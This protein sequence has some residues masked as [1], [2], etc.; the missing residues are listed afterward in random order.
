MENAE[1]TVNT[2]DEEFDKEGFAAD[3]FELLND[4]IPDEE[5]FE[6]D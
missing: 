5:D 1:E 2:K 6:D 3:L 4:L